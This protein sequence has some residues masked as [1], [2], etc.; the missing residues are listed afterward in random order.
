M[1]GMSVRPSKGAEIV[2]A[3]FA[4]VTI[5]MHSFQLSLY[6]AVIPKYF[7]YYR[8]R[9]RTNNIQQLSYMNRKRIHAGID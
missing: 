3:V 6:A 4:S 1:I 5:R 7:S 9:R 8:N 2:A